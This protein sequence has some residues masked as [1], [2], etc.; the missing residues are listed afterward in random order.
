MLSQVGVRYFKQAV[1][2][3]TYKE[4]P[5]DI[6]C[7]CPICGDSKTRKSAKRLHFYSKGS[8]E[9]VNC[10]NAGCAVQNKTIYSFLRDFYP[11]LLANYRKETF[12]T[13]MINLKKNSQ[14]SLGDLVNLSGL[15]E[16]VKT[17]ESTEPLI[18]TPVYIDEVEI[19]NISPPPL[20]ICI[21][22][23]LK[24]ITSE[25]TQ[26]LTGRGITPHFGSKWYTA[27][28]NFK[29]GDTY[30]GVED[31]LIIPL[32]ASNDSNIYGFYSR[33]IHEKDFKTCVISPGFKVWNL[34]NVDNSKETFIFEAIFDAISTGLENIIAN[35][36]AKLPQERLDEINFPVFCLDNDKAGI[37]NSIEYAKKGYKVYIQPREYSEKDFNELKLNYPELDISELIRSNIFQGISAITRLKLKL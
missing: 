20:T 32:T 12:D 37:E 21:D 8:V 23:F 3:S 16:Q 26:Y 27:S 33:S 29:I 19:K 24:E 18:D 2:A 9:L 13:S 31:Y 17:T 36:G 11:D 35:L 6:S 1:S 25:T 5:I 15:T 30:Y 7:S 4:T 34:Y 10:F 14:G 28:G 22:P